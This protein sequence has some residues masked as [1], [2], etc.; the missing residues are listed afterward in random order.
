MGWCW[1]GGGLRCVFAGGGD[2]ST[3][4]KK[5]KRIICHSL[6][7]SCSCLVHFLLAVDQSVS[8]VVPSTHTLHKLGSSFTET[9]IFRNFCFKLQQY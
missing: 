7:V 4:T 9:G 5:R 1:E 3:D 6:G 8:M 2:T